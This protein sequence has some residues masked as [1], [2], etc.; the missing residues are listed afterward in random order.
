MFGEFGIPSRAS[1]NMV[2]LSIFNLH[3]SSMTHLRPF[4]WSHRFARGWLLWVPTA[5]PNQNGPGTS[6]NS[7]IF[8]NVRDGDRCE[9]WGVKNL[10]VVHV[11]PS[12]LDDDDDHDYRPLLVIS[13]GIWNMFL[14]K[15]MFLC[16]SPL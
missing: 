9:E 10:M 15:D 3:G 5:T 6:S 13:F 1:S 7:S 16:S 14:C 4:A 8:G 11:V 12:I 2:I